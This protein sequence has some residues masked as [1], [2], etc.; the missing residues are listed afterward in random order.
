MI[1]ECL[2]T[3]C[4]LGGTSVWTYENIALNK[5]AW[6]LDTLFNYTSAKAVDGRKDSLSIFGSDCV[7]SQYNYTAEWRVDLEAVVSIHHIFI[8]YATNNLPWDKNNDHTARFLG[9]SVYISNTTNKADGILCFRDTKYTRATIPNPINITCPHHGRYVIYYNNRTSLPYPV[10]YSKD[11][12]NDLCEV[13]V[14][15]C[16]SPGYY[17]ENCSISCP[18]HCKDRRC[19]IVEGT[20]FECVDGYKGSTCSKECPQGYYGENCSIPCPVNCLDGLC[21]TE[22][23]TCHGCLDGSSGPTCN[24][25][26]TLPGY[27]GWNCSTPCPVNCLDGLCDTVNGTCNGC[28][29]GY[30]GSTCS[31]GC[32]QGY[33]GENCSIPCPVNCLEGLCDKENGTC[34]GCLNGS[35]GP[36]CNEGCSSPGYYGQNCSIPCPRNCL[37][38][39]C[40]IKKGTC[41]KCVDGYSGEKCMGK[42]ACPIQGQYGINCSTPCP[43]QCLEGL[44]DIVEG[45]CFE[46]VNGYKGPTCEGK[47]KDF[48]HQHFIGFG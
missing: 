2:L 16:T 34:Y 40:H 32:P 42:K 20:C 11:A 3:F 23:G 36:T 15:G 26:C 18:Q 44:C 35:S 6:Q 24:E 5:T 38:G 43:E 31:E 9:F 48:S 27:Y 21:D 47:D 8:Q 41:F 17:G 45:T 10:G 29:D 30:S 13:E 19:H 22:N 1:G 46:C 4:I 25:D 7:R 33:Y 12:G 39:R 14:Y 37:D 28:L